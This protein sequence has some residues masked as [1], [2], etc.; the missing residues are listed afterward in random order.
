MWDIYGGKAREREGCHW[1]VDTHVEEVCVMG[2]SPPR[3]LVRTRFG[4]LRLYDPEAGTLV[5]A[6][7]TD[8]VGYDQCQAKS[9]TVTR[10]EMGGEVI[11]YGTLSGTAVTVAIGGMMCQQLIPSMVQTGL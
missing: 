1:V 10:D 2:G 3:V 9:I 5:G 8:P 6:M 11:M 4:E 7:V